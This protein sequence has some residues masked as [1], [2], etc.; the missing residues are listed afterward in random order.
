MSSENTLFLEKEG[1]VMSR[2]SSGYFE[3]IAYNVD[4]FGNGKEIVKGSFFYDFIMFIKYSE[5]KLVSSGKNMGRYQE[6]FAEIYQYI[7]ALKALAI[8]GRMNSE[9]LIGVFSRQSR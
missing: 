5:R 2:G 8:T 1:I 6:G 9:K 7:Y 4:E 3:P